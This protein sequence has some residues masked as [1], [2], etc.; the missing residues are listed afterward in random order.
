[1]ILI[2]WANQLN[3]FTA[4]SYGDLSNTQIIYCP[5]KSLWCLAFYTIAQFA[6]QIVGYNNWLLL[7]TGNFDCIYALMRPRVECEFIA[8]IVHCTWWVIHQDALVNPHV[9]KL[10]NSS[11]IVIRLKVTT[12]RLRHFSRIY[13]IYKTFTSRGVWFGQCIVLA[14]S[15]FIFSAHWKS[16][17]AY[18]LSAFHST[19]SLSLHTH[20]HTHTNLYYRSSCIHVPT[21]FQL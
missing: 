19:C 13:T 2:V 15:F 4:L 1:M 16:G 20:T 6:I 11:N 3:N 7:N 17:I 18:C 9:G 12:K 5:H 10:V 14:V 8:Q 21:L